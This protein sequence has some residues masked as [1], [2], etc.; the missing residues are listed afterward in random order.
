MRKRRLL[1]CHCPDQRF[2]DLKT[3]GPAKLRFAGALGVRHHAKYVAPWTADARDIVQR[4]IW[5]RVRRD[6]AVGVGI[7]ENNTLV[8]LQLV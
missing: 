5:I 6:L 4:T 3:V 8:P 2:E 7:T 1:F